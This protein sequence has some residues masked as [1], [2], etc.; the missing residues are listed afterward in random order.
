[1]KDSEYRR[2]IHAYIARVFNQ[3]GSPT[4]EVG[5]ADDHVHVLCALGRNCTMSELVREA[6][7]NSSGW[8]KRFG[9]IL[10]KFEWQGGYGVF[11]VHVSQVEQIRAYIRDQETHHRTRSFHEEYLNILREYKVPYDERY[12]LK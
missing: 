9:G 7:A 11:S 8:I 1:M 4:I 12:L 6:K 10:S 5:G 3:R 2:R